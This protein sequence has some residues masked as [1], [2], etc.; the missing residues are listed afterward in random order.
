MERKLKE[1]SKLDGR[2]W[3]QINERRIALELVRDAVAT[4]LRV[5][6][7]DKYEWVLHTESE[8]QSHLQQLVHER[9]ISPLTKSS[10]SE[11]LEWQLCPIE[12][13][14]RMR[15]KL[16]HCKLTID[17]IQNVLTGQFELGRLELSKERTEHETNASDCSELYDGSIFK[18]SDDVRDA[19]SSRVGWNDD[20]DS[21][22]NEPS[23]SF[24]LE[25]GPKSSSA[26]VQKAESVQRKSDLGS[27]RQSSSLKADETRTV[28]DKSEKELTNNG[29]YLIRPHLEPY[30]RIKY[31]YNCKR[32]VGLDKHDS[33]WRTIVVHEVFSGS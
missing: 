26:S 16:E 22:I 13:P 18:D 14:Y 19:T 30:E 3:E 28:E 24:A 9:R 10:H 17:T 6:R 1:I 33:D 11:E 7:Q 23:L 20:H 2:H 31:K 5:I 12:G 15:K 27:P 29:E 25:L 8:W 4:E 21:S 32:V